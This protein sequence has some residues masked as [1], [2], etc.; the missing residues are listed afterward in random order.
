MKLTAEQLQATKHREGPALV[1]AVPGA[2]KTT[3]L[4]AR[5]MNLIRDGISPSRI[6]TITFSKASALDMQHRFLQTYG[7]ENTYFSTIHAFCYRILRDYGKMRGKTY[8]LL[9]SNPIKKYEIIRQIYQQTNQSYCTE[10]K[11]ETLLLELSYCKNAMVSPHS[12]EKSQLCETPNFERICEKYE[13]LKQ[14]KQFID[15]DDMITKTYQVFQSDSTLRTKYRKMF[16]Y[17][18]VDEG[19]DTSRSQFLFLQLLVKPKNNLFIVADDDQ[20]IY[21]FRGADPKEMFRLKQEYPDLATYYMEENFRSS[22]NIVNLSHYFIQK[23][24]DRF[25]KRIYTNNTYSEPVNIIKFQTC[26]EEYQFLLSEI[27]KYREEQN[28]I[29]FRNNLCAVGLV[30]FFEKHSV[31]FNIKDRKNKFFHHFIVSDILMILEFSKDLSRTD[32]YEKFYYKLKGYLSKKHIDFLRRRPGKNV[33]TT[34]M[35]Y[36]DLPEYYLRNISH[37]NRD[38]KKLT[39]L[40]FRE[41]IPFI[42]NELGYGQYLMENSKRLGYTYASLTEYLYY[43][44]LIAKEQNSL[45]E[46]IGRLKHLEYLLQK[47]KDRDA[48][49]TLTTMHSAKG[50]EFDNVFLVDL[51]E[52]T[53]PSAKSLEN[54]SQNPDLYEEERR[55]FYVAMTRAKK[56]LYLLYPSTRNDYENMESSFL[57]DLQEINVKEKE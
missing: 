19:Q 34:L 36:P 1:V 32:L 25:P 31:P 49:L 45:E 48:C 26:E 17:V 21:G 18:Q 23:N 52:G 51:L 37:L 9:D 10:E 13:G 39:H 4:L 46:F 53:I 8:F 57:L 27:G 56:K 24:R 47:P 28:A 11:M 35:T 30:E 14:R 40:S 44:K 7:I 50:L 5:T 2:G 16:D 38:F 42:E 22:K 6:L 3:M 41:S 43:L 55:L 54:I 15:F 20:S 12:F 29:L 33:F